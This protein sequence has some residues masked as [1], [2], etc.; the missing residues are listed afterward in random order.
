MQ[1]GHRK[2]RSAGRNSGSIEV[3]L[4]AQLQ[5]LEGVECRL[6]VRDGPRPEIVL[7]P[8]VSLAQNWCNSLWQQLRLGLSEIDEVGEFQLG[9]FSLALF[10]PAHWQER[11]PLAFADALLLARQPHPHDE[12]ALA[13]LARLLAS[14]ALV[15]A[16]RL[17]LRD[18]PALAFAD[19]VALLLTGVYVGLGSAFERGLTHQL[20]W[21]RTGEGQGQA[22]P[23]ERATWQRLRPEFRQMFEQLQG[24]QKN[25]AA[26]QAARE[27][28]YR[29]LA[30]E[31]AGGWK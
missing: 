21:G 30:V 22:N 7:Q 5:D 9:D 10:P 25:P 8:D 24:W 23:L 16:Q 20:V 13:A 3:T 28:W 1:L 12:R 2:I 17:Q 14:F 6:L 18:A 15:A 19:A 29:A 31:S 26:Y 11:P 27:R 4:P